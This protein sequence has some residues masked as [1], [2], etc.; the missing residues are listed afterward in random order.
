MVSPCL[1]LASASP[2]SKSIPFWGSQRAQPDGLQPRQA[3]SS[4]SHNSHCGIMRQELALGI[5]PRMGCLGLAAW[6][7][8]CPSL[9]A[10]HPQS[11]ERDRAGGSSGWETTL[12]WAGPLG[13]GHVTETGER[14]AACACH[15][16]RG[17]W[18]GKRRQ[19][20][21]KNR[22]EDWEGKQERKM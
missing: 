5:G 12:P 9:G 15:F 3:S 2:T 17:Q 22:F 1:G 8:L 21:K 13:Q 10:G 14:G 18:V 6:L 20:G 4:R 11:T 19:K 16:G 7:A